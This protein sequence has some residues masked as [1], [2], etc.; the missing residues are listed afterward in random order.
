M[1]GTTQNRAYARPR[2]GMHTSRAVLHLLAYVL[3]FAWLALALL[4]LFWMLST[5]LKTSEQLRI[6]LPM[7]W[8]PNPIHWQNYVEGWQEQPWLHYLGNTMQWAAG[9][10]VGLL[11]SVTIAAYAFARMRFRGR[12]A[13][14]FLNIVLMLLPG[15]VTMVPIFVL[16]SKLGFVGSW[17]PVMVPSFLAAAPHLVFLLRQFFRTIPEE[18]CDAARVDGASEARIFF[19]IV[20][21]LSVPVLTTISVLT[22]LWAW[23]DFLG[24]LLYLTNPQAFTM[25]LGL[26]DFQGRHEVA[27]NLLMAASVVFTLP[28]IV[29]FFFAQR[30]FIQG[31]K[32]TGL[33]E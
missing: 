10:S 4:P 15:Q 23:N 32:L 29:A 18:L 30:T 13:L 14:M 3:V 11:L 17:A 9:T 5:S 20:L 26:Q 28:I 33:K 24:P 8:I 6:T 31:V 19:N 21:P 25:A 22:F 2:L 1:S 16:N 7:Q 12:E 27:W